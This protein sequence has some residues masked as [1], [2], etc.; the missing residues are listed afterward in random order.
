MEKI[1]VGIL[2][3]RN[4]LGSGYRKQTTFFMPN[5]LMIL[6]TEMYICRARPGSHG[7]APLGAAR[8]SGQTSLPRF[9][10]WARKFPAASFRLARS[11][12]PYIQQP[13]V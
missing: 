8:R 7:D 3:S 9:R 5:R 2:L 10:L 6:L 12:V 13:A 11:W 4:L 1:R